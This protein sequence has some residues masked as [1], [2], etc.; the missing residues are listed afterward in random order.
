MSATRYE[1]WK[2]W[3]TDPFQKNSTLNPRA[4]E[5]SAGKRMGTRKKL[6]GQSLMARKEAHVS[7]IHRPT[8]QTHQK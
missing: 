6:H 3:V 2:A 5:P 7:V 8:P 1:N 4:V